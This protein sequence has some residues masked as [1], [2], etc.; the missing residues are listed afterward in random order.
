MPPPHPVVS[1]PIKD[2]HGVVQGAVTIYHM[3]PRNQRTG[4]T[5]IASLG[6]QHRCRSYAGAPALLTWQITAAR[7]YFP[8]HCRNALFR[9]NLFPQGS[10]RVEYRIEARKGNRKSRKKRKRRLQR[11]RLKS[12]A[13]AMHARDL[14]FLRCLRF[15]LLLADPA[16]YR[17]PET[18]ARSL[19]WF[20]CGRSAALG[21]LRAS[22]FICVRTFLVL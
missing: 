21:I 7:G 15:P 17:R 6:C 8:M 1:A 19:L 5:P 18:P 13:L 2:R 10:W 16:R 9:L 4:T 12:G 14:R 22:F 20:G 11:H 3:V